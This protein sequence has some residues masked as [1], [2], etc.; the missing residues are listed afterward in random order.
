MGYPGGTMS[1]MLRLLAIAFRQAIDASDVMSDDGL[2]ESSR[3]PCGDVPLLLSEFL[4]KQGFDE[5]DY[6]VGRARS[7]PVPHAAHGWLEIGGTIVDITADQYRSRPS[8][9]VLVTRDRSW[10]AY[11]VE[12][13]RSAARLDACDPT[14]VVPLQALYG[15]I[16]KHLPAGLRGPAK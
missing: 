2:R 10:H 13:S 15:R 16:V 12:E 9:P 11:F 4:R 3:G 5:I 14:A 8:A 6:V 7:G 1:N